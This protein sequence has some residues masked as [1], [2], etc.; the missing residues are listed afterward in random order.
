[1]MAVRLTLDIALPAPDWCCWSLG[2][3]SKPPHAIPE[4]LNEA[5]NHVNT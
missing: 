5:R 2:L 4:V 1:M 3:I